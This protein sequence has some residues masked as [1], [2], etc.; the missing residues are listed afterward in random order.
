MVFLHLL[1]VYMKKEDKK[2][3]NWIGIT[4]LVLAAAVLLLL[5]QRL[6]FGGIIISAGLSALCPA[7]ILGS[8]PDAYKAVCNSLSSIG[9]RS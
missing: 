4:F 8:F 6:W 5:P 9:R 3:L 7:A 2:V 1:K